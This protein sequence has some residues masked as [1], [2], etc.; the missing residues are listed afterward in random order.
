MS[1]IIGIGNA[2]VDKLVRLHDENLLSDLHLVKGAMIFIDQ[3]QYTQLTSFLCPFPCEQ[4]SGG[5][6]SNTIMALALL[7]DETGFIGTVGD[8]ELGR[9]YCSHAEARGTHMYLRTLAQPTGVATTFITPDGER[10]FADFMGAAPCVMSDEVLE[11]LPLDE[12]Y[13]VLHV[14]GYLALEPEALEKLLQRY[15]EAGVK[16]SFDLA[17]WNLVAEKRAYL[18]DLLSRYVDIVFANEEEAAAFTG[19]EDPEFNVRALAALTDVAI[20]K[21]GKRGALGMTRHLEA[22]VFVEAHNGA[23]VDT[24]AAGDFFAAGFLHAYTRAESLYNSLNLGN[25]LAGIVIQVIGTQVNPDDVRA[26]VKA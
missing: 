22:P 23:P 8:D 6:A 17:S 18:Q 1:K 9:F 20:V 2:L 11:H 15:H 14:E 16:I 12:S 7:G 19:N 21:V 24:T 26:L 10:S 5:S 25:H 4:A 3:P 13:D